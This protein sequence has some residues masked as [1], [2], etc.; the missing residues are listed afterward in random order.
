MDA[1]VG[2]FQAFELAT[3][4]V[5][6]GAAASSAKASAGTTEAAASNPTGGKSSSEQSASVF[7]EVAPSRAAA[8]PAVLMV[9]YLLNVSGGTSRVSPDGSARAAKPDRKRPVRGFP[10]A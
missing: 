5:H 10:R 1:G 2:L 6:V 9:S 8:I 7:G 4:P 3:T